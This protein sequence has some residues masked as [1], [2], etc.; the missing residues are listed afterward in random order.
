MAADTGDRASRSC[1]SDRSIALSS[2]TAG[3]PVGDDDAAVRCP[4]PVAGPYGG[5]RPVQPAA[6]FD[7]KQR[8]DNGDRRAAQD[9]QGRQRDEEG[10]EGDGH[11][12]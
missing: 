12:T 4:P 3:T 9:D 1:P 10:D 6:P 2:Q 5:R 11:L 8:P 7:R